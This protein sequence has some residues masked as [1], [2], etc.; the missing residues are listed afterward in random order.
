MFITRYNSG[1]FPDKMRYP[2]DSL[3]GRILTQLNEVGAKYHEVARANVDKLQE[4]MPRIQLIGKWREDAIKEFKEKISNE[5]KGDE[6]SDMAAEIASGLAA[7][8][9]HG[10]RGFES[11]ITK[12]LDILRYSSEEKMTMLRASINS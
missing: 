5:F 9:F 3:G 6:F 11:E 7:S 12:G 2:K 8:Y 10:S 4:Y 1:R